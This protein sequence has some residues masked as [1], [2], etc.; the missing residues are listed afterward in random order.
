MGIADKFKLLQA[1]LWFVTGLFILAACSSH[2][3]PR[4]H[5]AVRLTGALFLL[6]GCVS[7][8]EFVV[9]AISAPTWLL[10]WKTLTV[11]AL[12]ACVTH[13]FWEHKRGR[14]D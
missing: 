13:L 11:A 10:A 12:L 3:A 9:V 14:K 1:L 8:A 6:L 2:F 5:T 7:V 4:H